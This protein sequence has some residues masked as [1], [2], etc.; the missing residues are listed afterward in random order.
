MQIKSALLCFGTLFAYIILQQFITSY[1]PTYSATTS[2][3][4]SC[5]SEEGAGKLYWEYQICIL[6]IAKDCR[7]D[8]LSFAMPSSLSFANADVRHHGNHTFK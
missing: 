3:T 6:M 5:N 2:Y 1:H 8:P 7:R 4:S